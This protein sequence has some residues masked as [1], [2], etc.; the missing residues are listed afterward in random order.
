MELVTNFKNLQD[1]ITLVK[2]Y[3]K[4]IV[5]NFFMDEGKIDQWI[6]KGSFYFLEINQT[7]FLIKKRNDFLSLYFISSSIDEIRISL[8]TLLSNFPEKLFVAD[9]IVKD[10]YSELI[11]AFKDSNFYQY[12]CLVRMSRISDNSSVQLVSQNNMRDASIN[13]LE[14]IMNLFLENFDPLS[15]QIPDKFDLISW[16]DCGRILVYEVD[17]KVAGFII[18][19]L[20]G[21]TLY[22]RYWF[23]H[24]EHREQKIGSSLFNYFL[25]KGKDTKRQIF[26]VIDTNENAIKR[27]KHYG[28][29]EEKMYNFVMTNKN[30]K[31]ER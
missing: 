10:L 21:L 26:W 12:T 9:I 31:Y 7:L 22:L 29:N 6:E 19:D 15:E 18:F 8:P 5:T 4:K 16:I 11:S 1:K 20:T 13:D 3:D 28:F 24:P 2:S 23:V 25:F 17:S 27:Y 14:Q 30:K